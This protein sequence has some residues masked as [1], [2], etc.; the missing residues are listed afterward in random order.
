MA[1]F[2]SGITWN[3]GTHTKPIYHDQSQI[4][5]IE[6]TISTNALKGLT[7][8]IMFYTIVQL[9]SFQY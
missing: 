8:A 5:E 9:T 6:V 2:H 7:A 1:R 4:I 3:F